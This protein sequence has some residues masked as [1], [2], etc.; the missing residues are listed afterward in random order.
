MFY[1]PSLLHLEHNPSGPLDLAFGLLQENPPEGYFRLGAIG[2]EVK[3]RHSYVP[4]T[5]CGNSRRT[6]EVSSFGTILLGYPLV[7]LNMLD[8]ENGDFTQLENCDLY[9]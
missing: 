8:P 3:L 9:P 5:I 2:S 1:S 4:S 6:R 7:N